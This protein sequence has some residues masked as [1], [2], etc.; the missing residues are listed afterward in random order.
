MGTNCLHLGHEINNFLGGQFQKIPTL[1]TLIV[2]IA[3]MVDGEQKE[4]TLTAP[5]VQIEVPVAFTLDFTP[6]P[7][8]A[9]L[10]LREA[11]LKPKN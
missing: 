6:N 10:K 11:W 7:T 5:N 9:Q 8:A 1:D 3:R 4:M 2:T